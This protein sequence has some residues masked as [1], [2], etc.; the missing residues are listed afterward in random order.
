MTVVWHHEHHRHARNIAPG[1]GAIARLMVLAVVVIVFVCGGAWFYLGGWRS[2]VLPRIV[3]SRLYVPIGYDSGDIV[4][5][6][7]IARLARGIAAADNRANVTE[8]DYAQAL[9][10]TVRRN[11]L[12]KLAKELDVSV[13][14]ETV[15]ESV[16]WTS[17]IRAFQALAGWSDDEYVNYVVR[18]FVLSTAVEQALL[19]SDAYRDASIARMEDIQ[20]KITL[21]IAFADLAKEYSEDPVTAASR[22]SFGY[23]LPA[24]VDSAFA[25]VFQLPVNTVSEVITTLDAYWVLRTEDTLVDESGV[26]VLLRGIAVKKASLADVLDSLTIESDPVLWVQ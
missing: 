23:V 22:G 4:W 9:D 3:E 19:V 7:A 6:P 10:A 20:A 17:D 1:R 25:P 2:G 18:V 8:L 15:Q 21:G 11:A 14:E 5:Y 24:E 13:A 16:T 12:E 26:R